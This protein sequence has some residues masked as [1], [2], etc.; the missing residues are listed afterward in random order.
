MLGINASVIQGSGLGPISFLFNASDLH[1][2]NSEN[3]ICKYA[4]DFY[5]I[6]P[7]SH[8]HTIP[9]ELENIAIWAGKNNLKLNQSK[10]HEMIV[11]KPRADS[12]TNPP[13]TTHG[14][15]RVREMVVLGVTLTDTLSFRPHVDRIVAQLTYASTAWT[16]F[17]NCEDK[18][19]LQ[20]VLMKL[21]RSGFLSPPPNCQTF[22]QICEA[23]D[24][25][26]FSST[27]HND[28]HVLHQLLPPVKTHTHNLRKRAHDFVIPRCDDSLMR[29]N[30]II[31]LISANSF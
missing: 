28:D 2:L 24:A 5:L 25:Q 10:S 16:G 20:G 29:K 31:R 11:R 1:P 7:S 13:A 23:A 27:I 12:S 4:D 3:K 26:L 6:V 30:F 22:L 17:I 9:A 14:I 18:A 21:Q 15:E 8:S 19:R